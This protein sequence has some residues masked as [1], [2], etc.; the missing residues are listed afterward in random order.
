[1]GKGKGKNSR[2][3]GGGEDT[4]AP[5]D[6]HQSY[7]SYPPPTRSTEVGVEDEEQEEEGEEIFS[8]YDFPVGLF[9]WEFGQ[10]D[11]KR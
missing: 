11:P 6:D 8:P 2:G 4:R 1:M 9:M 7:G 3:R 10:N 5:R